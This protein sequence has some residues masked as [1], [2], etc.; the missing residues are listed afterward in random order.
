MIGTSCYSALTGRTVPGGRGWKPGQP[1][2]LWMRWAGFLSIPVGIWVVI[3]ALMGIWPL[4]PFS[5]VS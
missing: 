2:S 3:A 5:H 4:P 1:P